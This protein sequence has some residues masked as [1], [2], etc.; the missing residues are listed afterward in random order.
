MKKQRHRRTVFKCR[1]HFTFLITPMVFKMVDFQKLLIEPIFIWGFNSMSRMS[2]FKSWITLPLCIRRVYLLNCWFWSQS[3]FFQLLFY[4][5]FLFFHF[6]FSV[7]TC[8]KINW[9][10]H[11]NEWAHFRFVVQQVLLSGNTVV[12]TKITKHFH[13]SL[14]KSHGR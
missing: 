4:F 5:I 14:W 1:Y 11:P 8:Y 12:L 7:S 3:F 9:M 6:I 2:C 13:N 10:E